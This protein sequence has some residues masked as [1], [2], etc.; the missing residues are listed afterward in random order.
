[1]CRYKASDIRQIDSRV[2][3]L[4]SKLADEEHKY[5]TLTFAA[6]AYAN[7]IRSKNAVIASLQDMNSDMKLNVAAANLK[8]RSTEDEFRVLQFSKAEQDHC[9]Y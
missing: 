1:M 5:A 2:H 7:D 6:T 4:K 8:L 3:F 9:D